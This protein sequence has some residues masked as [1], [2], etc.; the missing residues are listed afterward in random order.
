MPKIPWRYYNF[1]SLLKF[2]R[3][4]SNNLMQRGP[5][6]LIV[7]IGYFLPLKK[8]LAVPVNKS[9][10]TPSPCGFNAICKEQNNVGSCTCLADYVGNPYEGCRPECVVDTD[11]PSTQSCIR[12]RCQDPCPG[13]CGTNAEC[14]VINH[15]PACTC[16]QGYSGNPFQH[17]A[18]IREIGTNKQTFIPSCI[19]HK[20]L[21]TKIS[22]NTELFLMVLN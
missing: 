6:T 13:T 15:R 10:C 14:K 5:L 20:F 2:I 21:S 12:S 16:I 4:R 22:K 9:P 7:F 8:F 1:R 11:C 18:L 17:C 19:L 3:G